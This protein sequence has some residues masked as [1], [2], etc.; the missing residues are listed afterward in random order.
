MFAPR[1][2]VS[3]D[4][5][6]R[7]ALGG[8]APARSAHPVCRADH[9]VDSETTPTDGITQRDIYRIAQLGARAHAP[10]Y[11]RGTSEVH[12][13][14]IGLPTPAGQRRSAKVPTFVANYFDLKSLRAEVWLW[15]QARRAVWAWLVIWPGRRS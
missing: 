1:L 14:Y 9:G 13:R 6:A 2:L 10:R 8:L 12:A 5:I 3:P 7:A 15:W 4:L 11:T